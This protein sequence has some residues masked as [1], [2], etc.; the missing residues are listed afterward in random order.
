MK[1]LRVSILAFLPLLLLLARP[2]AS[3]AETRYISDVLVVSLREAP[4][5]DA[6]LIRT[7]LTGTHLE[8]LEEIEGYVRVRAP[9]GEEGWVRSQYVTRETPKAEVIARY[10][11][12]TERLKKK[13]A[14]LEERLAASSEKARSSVQ[15]ATARLRRLEKDLKAARK[16]AS[17]LKAELAEVTEKYTALQENARNVVAITEERDRLLEARERLTNEVDHLT[18]ENR[19]LMRTGMIKWFL[20]GAGVLLVGWFAGKRSRRRRFY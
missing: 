12:E 7:L 10:E 19:R 6:K 2:G 9:G 15:E 1:N 18:N 11:K 13:V 3:A 17:G 20:A 5:A 4:A 16:E 14:E 8:V